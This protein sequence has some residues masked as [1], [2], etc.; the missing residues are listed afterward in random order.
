[1]ITKET[2]L[3]ST[4]TNHDLK[5]ID[6][7]LPAYQPSFTS[8]STIHL[9]HQL[10]ASHHRPSAQPGRMSRDSEDRKQLR[11][12]LEN[13]KPLTTSWAAGPW[14]MG[15]LPTENRYQLEIDRMVHLGFLGPLIQEVPMVTAEGQSIN[16]C[17]SVFP[18]KLHTCLGKSKKLEPGRHK[19]HCLLS[20]I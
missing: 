19:T 13:S 7:H 4:I 9:H 11:S 3:I 8:S 14:A 17:R 15:A 18:E 16:P 10:Q 1:M 12:N 5:I 6:H 20:G 2:V